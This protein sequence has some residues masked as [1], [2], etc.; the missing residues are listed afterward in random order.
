MS[1]EDLDVIDRVADDL[2]RNQT[3]L[4][5]SDHLEW[6]AAEGEHLMLLQEKITTYL[7]FVESGRIYS[8]HP[9]AKGKSLA[10]LVFFKYEPKGEMVDFFMPRI[11]KFLTDLGIEWQTT[12][13]KNSM[14]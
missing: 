4:V 1:V 10:I 6:G 3:V 13:I 7:G 8:V 5:I 12:R 11:E 9:S 14:N 2:K